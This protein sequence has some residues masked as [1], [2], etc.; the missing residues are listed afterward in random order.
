MENIYK[1]RLLTPGPTPI[2]DSVRLVM[3][4]PMVHHRK[5]AFKDA[6]A[7]NQIMLKKLFGTSQEV[8]TLSSSGT[9]AMVAA[10]HGLFAPGETVLVAQAGKFGER[11]EE[12]A[13]AH[14]LHVISLTAPWG[15]AIEPGRVEQ[16]LRENPAISGLLIQL[17]ETSTGVQHPVEA[18]AAITRK[19]NTLLVV[20]GISSVGI[21]PAPMDEW[22]IDCLLTGSQK[23]L[24]VPPGLALIALSERAWQ[25]TTR[26]P[27][28]SYYFDLPA[29]RKNCLKNQTHFTSPVSLVMALRTAL[30]Q[31][32]AD[33][34]PA[35]YRK[36]WALTQLTRSGIQAMG[37]KPFAPTH[38][39]WGLTSVAMPDGVKAS[40]ITKKAH[41]NW[42]VI[43]TAGQEPMK[44]EMVRLAH[45][46]YVDFADILAGLVALQRSMPAGTT[47]PHFL[48]TAMQAYENAMGEKAIG[49]DNPPQTPLL[50]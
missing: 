41:Q 33:G 45:M 43:L 17:S 25:K 38:Y 31:I 47:S 13:T 3:A 9:G 29:E 35:L 36:Q 18:I 1:M 5:D 20:D 24:M 2:P 37:L 48:D 42:N 32:F 27:P 6:L 8:L 22:G 11:W 40:D 34:L 49:G 4:E 7:E 26:V 50:P 30:Q 21:S 19:T 10:V 46:G 14:G 23:G 16:A 12:I 44:D 28:T 15:Q 39:T